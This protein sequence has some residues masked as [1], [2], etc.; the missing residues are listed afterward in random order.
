MTILLLA[1]LLV[2]APSQEPSG[3]QAG[4][5][6]AAIT[7]R[8]PIWMAGYAART[9]PSEGKTH[10]LWAKAL[11]IKD[12]RGKLAVLVTIDVCGVGAEVSNAVRNA[13]KADHGLDRDRIVLACSHTHS[14][15][16]VGKNLI[17]MYR[18][19]DAELER[20]DTYTKA[21][22]ETLG[23]LIGQAIDE[24]EAA[25]LSW[26]AGRADFAVNRRANKE[27]DVPRLRDAFNLQGPVDHDVPV[28]K[29]ADGDGHI[30]AVVCGYACHC[31]VLD[32]QQLSGDYAGFAQAD[33]EAAHPG[34]QAMFVAGCGGDQNPIPR[35]SVELAGEYGKALAKAVDDVLAG[36]LKKVE[37]PLGT[38]YEEIMLKFA[39]LPTRAKVEAD[40]K[41]KD[42]FI[43]SRAKALLATIEA[44]GSLAATYPYPI[45]SWTLGNLTWIFLGGEVVVDY[46][47]RIKRNLG[48][49]RT[50][51][52]AY[53]NDVM[54]YIPS[55]RV[56][57]EGGY[58]GGA[59]MLYYGQPTT[60][61]P[62]VEDD[63]IAAI[64]RQVRA[65]PEP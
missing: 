43:A 7:P 60:W 45:Q 64:A 33:I 21:L 42:F 34:V 20:I 23:T 49:S 13:A 35:R 4:T 51:I 38:S 6:K 1:A 27:A 57:M 37:G 22:I 3:W 48:S 46:S 12:P 2:V 19:D 32:G 14:G 30:K 25:D 5:A 11:A 62:T 63:I 59:A 15:P 17:T 53:C 24:L 39:E 54:A 44:K 8:G 41:S 28:L 58:E 36:S 31:T 10:D 29:V 18:L 50:W 47:L 55:A 52:S 40:T 9:K 26:S 65:K 61:A 16:V 56:L